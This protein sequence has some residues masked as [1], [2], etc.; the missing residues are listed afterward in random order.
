MTR[1]DDTPSPKKAE[2]AMP[3]ARGVCLGSPLYIIYAHIKFGSARIFM[4]ARDT[5]KTHL[6]F[7]NAAGC[8]W[9]WYVGA[10]MGIWPD[11]CMQE[12]A[13][14]KAGGASGCVMPAAQNYSREKA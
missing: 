10:H 4:G 11:K 9:M 7:F 5:R 2:P 14:E 8:V 6:I 3:A 1:H 12:K 13:G